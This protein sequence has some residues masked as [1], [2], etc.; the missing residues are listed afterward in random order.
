MN[1]A[2]DPLAALAEL[3]ARQ[4]QMQAQLQPAVARAVARARARG[5][6]WQE[7][8]NA[9]GVSKQAAWERWGP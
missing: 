8:A 9:L 3:R 5:H 6:T 4:A 7:I 2:A 1:N